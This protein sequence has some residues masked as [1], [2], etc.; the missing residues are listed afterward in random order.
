MKTEKTIYLDGAA[1]T[2]LDSS[3]FKAM[4][5]YLEGYVGNS[6]SVHAYGA[7]AGEAINRSL[8]TMAS[9][10][11]VDKEDIFV[12]SSSTESNNWVI[13]M[14][15]LNELKKGDKAKKH[16]VCMSTEHSSILK[17]CEQMKEFGAEVTYVAPKEYFSRDS[18]EREW[19]EV[20][21]PNTCLVCAMAVN[22]ELGT[23]NQVEAIAQKALDMGGIPTLV[24]CTQLLS[25]GG[26]SVEL[27]YLY[28]SATYF[29]FS[30]HKFYGPTGVGC[31]IMKTP[32]KLPPLIAGGGQQGGLRGGTMDT[33][34][35]VGM[36]TALEQ[37]HKEDYFSYFYD[38]FSHLI[39]TLDSKMPGYKLNAYPQH[40]NI[41]S[42]N[43]SGIFNEESLAVTLS[44]Y[45]VA[46]SAGSACNA[47]QE[48]PENGFVPSHVL[49]AA[50]LDERQIRN[51]I[52]VSFT[53][54]TTKDEIDAFVDKLLELREDNKLYDSELV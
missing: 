31:L 21:T 38:L 43:L 23:L 11:K 50:G 30:A 48:D 39:K 13:K 2:P 4:S 42:L 26:S 33:A 35:I 8:A 37:I 10:L 25:Y 44:N 9:A 34:G 54:Y 41:I 24:D 28:P 51:T 27:G 19:E 40:Y 3:V 53:K 17:C 5:P 47:A 29:S 32:N 18:L 6:M 45:G 20:L 52:R 16:I 14:T 15:F 7:V 12:T 36:A 46:V 49:V 1:T 22:N